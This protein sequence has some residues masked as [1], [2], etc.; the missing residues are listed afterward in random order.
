MKLKNFTFVFM[1]FLLAGMG[2]SASAQTPA[3]GDYVFTGATDATWASLG[4]WSVSDGA[5]NLTLASALPSASNN[6]WI[7]TGTK[8]STTTT[9][10]NSNATWTSGSNTVTLSS[11]NANIA[12]GM[13]VLGV[14]IPSGTTVS[15]I[16]GTAV[17]L[18]LNATAT[19]SSAS[20]LYFTPVGC[21]NLYVAG[22]FTNTSAVNVVGNVTVHGTAGKISITSSQPFYI[23]GDLT[24]NATDSLYIGSSNSTAMVYCANIYNYGVVSAYSD[25]SG[26]KSYLYIG[27]NGANP[28][29][30]DYTIVNDAIFGNPAISIANPV[31]KGGGIKLLYSESAASLTIKP[32]SASV[33]GYAF[34][35][36][37]IVS[38]YSAATSPVSSQP[39]ALNLNQNMSL[40][41]NGAAITLSLQNGNPTTATRTLNIPAG[42]TVYC[43]G[44]FH[45]N[46]SVSG[47][48]AQDNFVYNVYGTLDLATN[49]YY[50]AG[51]PADFDLCMTTNVGNTGK[52]TFNLGD[53]SNPASLV[54]GKSVKLIKQATQSIDFNFNTNSTVTFA[55]S[56]APKNIGSTVFQLQNINPSNGTYNPAVYL[57]PSKFYNLTLNNDSTILPV[58]PKYKGTLTKTAS[59]YTI[60]TWFASTTYNT[61]MAPG[62]VVNTGSYYYYVPVV[63]AA[64]SY[65]SGSTSITLLSDTILKY[66]YPGQVVTSSTSGIPTST[67]VSSTGFAAGSTTVPI[68]AAT[69]AAATS[70]LLTF[71]K[72]V[73]AAS[74]PTTTY[75][76]VF[77]AT[78]NPV[79]DGSQYLIYLGST[80]DFLPTP[81]SGVNDTKANVAKVYTEN[82]KL[83]ISNANI[84]DPITVYTIT[85]VK[86]SSSVVNSSD[87]SISLSSGIYLVKVGSQVSKVFV[88]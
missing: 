51:Y 57:F 1:L 31:T 22:K 36:G 16:S 63:A 14:G 84:G 52:I 62:T 26:L 88:K 32:S 28:G 2:I 74:A 45:S 42:V 24:V 47:T 68:S 59:S 21:K 65:T 73:S 77:T 37:A 5:G 43:G 53:G 10:T 49:I 18:S 33:T 41:W 12:V 76:D 9:S 40:L 15:S 85:G 46:R 4:N 87:V 70:A 20:A 54:I 67:T 48:I 58:S 86:S 79:L 61:K 60:P 39:F 64:G 3:S 7:P 66:V 55:T 81:L 35:I 44:P 11:A 34:N 25:Y 29:S 23:Q 50:N 80:S 8:L 13:Y 75:S 30:G 19:V 78:Y 38:N 56:T 72:G 27:Y 17:T 6:V 82:K 71:T 83:F 69:T